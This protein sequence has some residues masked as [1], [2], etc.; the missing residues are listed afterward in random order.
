MILDLRSNFDCEYCFGTDSKLVDRYVIRPNNIYLNN[1]VE[2]FN[3]YIQF[4][5]AIGLFNYLQLGDFRIK[6]L[7]NYFQFTIIFGFFKH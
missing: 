1:I 4:S 6:L 5:I 2:F 3:Y 7:N